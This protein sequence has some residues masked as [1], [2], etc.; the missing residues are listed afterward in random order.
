M[1]KVLIFY[2]LQAACDETSD[3]SERAFVQLLLMANGN[4]NNEVFSLA[5]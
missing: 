2:H 3:K 5:P 4:N 1:L